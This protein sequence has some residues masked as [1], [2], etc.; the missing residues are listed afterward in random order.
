M[1]EEVNLIKESVV[2][3]EK[4][5]ERMEDITCELDLKVREVQGL[6]TKVNRLN[7]QLA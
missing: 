2:E 3:L 1:I 4:K 5:Q 6:E 7:E